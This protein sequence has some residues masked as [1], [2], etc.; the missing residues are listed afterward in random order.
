VHLFL[1]VFSIGADSSVL[2]NC[3]RDGT[4]FTQ[5]CSA[6]IENFANVGLRTLVSACRLVS[7][8]E[9]DAWLVDYR[10]AAN[11]IQHRGELLSACAR[12]IEKDMVM[13]GAIGIEDELQDGVPEVCVRCNFNY[14]WFE[15]DLSSSN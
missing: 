14:V 3:K 9:A 11:D 10:A 15:L 1:F 12:K 7:Q 8:A 4:A 13:L 5:Q 6:H 2:K